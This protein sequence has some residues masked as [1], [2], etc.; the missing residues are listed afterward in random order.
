M[1]HNAKRVSRI[2]TTTLIL[3]VGVFSPTFASSSP[4]PY[5][6]TIAELA[7]VK[8]PSGAADLTGSTLEAEWI[9]DVPASSFHVKVFTPFERRSV[10]QVVLP[11][12]A[13]DF[14]MSV[15]DGTDTIVFQVGAEIDGT[16]YWDE[17]IWAWD[18]NPPTQPLELVPG[19][20][21][22]A[23]WTCGM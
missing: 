6:P 17:E 23:G 7:A 22:R 20:P 19:P 9:T 21:C 5:S 3:L 15:P 13:R 11:G 8:S 16:V 4:I 14:A 10:T 12:D 18:S 1:D 2:V